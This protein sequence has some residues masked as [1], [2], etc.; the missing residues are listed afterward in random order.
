MAKQL[1]HEIRVRYSDCDPQ[2]I[3]FFARHLEYCDIAMGELWREAIG[4]YDEMVQ[5]GA[6]M[7]VAEA[8][9]RYS[10]PLPFDALAELR[11]TVRHLGTTSMR[12]DVEIHSG[13]K[14][15]S[16]AELRHVFV[17]TDGSGKTEIPPDVRAALEA[18]LES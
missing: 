9:I 14:L 4:P 12:T 1:V 15:C 8:S 6:D 16:A 18:Y 5:A 2:G 13:G 17:A 10:S 11:A 3:V 7:V